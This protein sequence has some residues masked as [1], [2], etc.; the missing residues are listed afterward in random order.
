MASLPVG[1][2]QRLEILK[3]LYRKAR[4]LVLDEPTAVL[5]PPEVAS[6]FDVMRRLAASGCTVLLVTHKLDE[7]MSV[8]ERITVLREGRVSADLV[9]ANTSPAEIIHAMTGRSSL[10][11]V[12]RSQLAPGEVALFSRSPQR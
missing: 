8:S 7:A 4:V 1:V 11:P 10:R 9:T 3:A 5:T 2:R 6:L 12:T